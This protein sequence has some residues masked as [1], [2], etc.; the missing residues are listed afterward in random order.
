MPDVAAFS[1]VR[2]GDPKASI[3]ARQPADIIECVGI[4]G[5]DD[6]Y[7]SLDAEPFTSRNGVTSQ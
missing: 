1:I 4:D 7:D 2:R 6:D 3:L 5:Q